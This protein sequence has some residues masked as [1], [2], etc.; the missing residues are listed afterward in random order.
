MQRR[1]LHREREIQAS[2]ESSFVIHQSTDQN[3]H[4]RKQVESGKE[5]PNPIRANIFKASTNS[6]VHHF[7]FFVN[8]Q[9]AKPFDSQITETQQTPSPRTIKTAIP[10]HIMMNYSKPV[11]KRTSKSSPSLKRHITV[12]RRTNIKMTLQISPSGLI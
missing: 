4:V 8:S 5:P 10:S 7:F 3:M 12:H 9:R 6:W 1:E 2:S 11:L